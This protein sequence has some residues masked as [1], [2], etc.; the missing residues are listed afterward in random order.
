MAPH[1]SPKLAFTRA[2]DVGM[3]PRYMLDTGAYAGRQE[4]LNEAVELLAKNPIELKRALLFRGR[5]A[6]K[7]TIPGTIIAVYSGV[8]EPNDEEQDVRV[9]EYAYDGPLGVVYKNGILGI[10]SDRVM[11]E[12]VKRSR[13]NILSK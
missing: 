12:I 5:D 7:Y 2:K 13:E 10:M 3:L 9:S 8:Q 6:L 11:N 1:V 4:S